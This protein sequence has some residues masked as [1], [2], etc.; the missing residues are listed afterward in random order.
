MRD[1]AARRADDRTGGGLVE[2]QQ[3]G[4]PDQGDGHVETALL[5]AG[6][7]AGPLAALIGQ[8]DELDGLLHRTG[9]RVVDG[10]EG[11]GLGHGEL[12]LHPTALEHDAQAWR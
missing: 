7:L 12:G 3:L 4:S 9:T 11:D 10:V 5:A 1:Q 8:P 2:E 6:E